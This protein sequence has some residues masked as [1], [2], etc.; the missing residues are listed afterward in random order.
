MTTTMETMPGQVLDPPAEGAPLDPISSAGLSLT[1]GDAAGYA[2]ANREHDWPGSLFIFLANLTALLCVIGAG[3]ALAGL[4]VDGLPMDGKPWLAVLFV[5]AAVF[6]RVLATGVRRFTRWGWMGAMAELGVAALTEL[7]TSLDIGDW[8]SSII[9]VGINVL[10]MSY[11]WRRR[12][13]F[14]IDIDL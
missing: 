2:D 5:V 1:A 13:D 12:A 11:F 3:V 4:V 10:W 6:Q 9:T 7:P 8:V 14:D